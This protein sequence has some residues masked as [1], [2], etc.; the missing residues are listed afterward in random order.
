MEKEKTAIAHE[1]AVQALKAIGMGVWRYYPQQEKL[2]WDEVCRGIYHWPQAA[3]TFSQ[4]MDAIH[5]D[6]LLSA[7]SVLYQKANLHPNE[8]AVMEYRFKS[9]AHKGYIWI[10]VTG[11]CFFNAEGQP[12][13]LT[14]TAVDV[15]AEKETAAAEG[16]RKEAE[17]LSV[18]ERFRQAFENAAVGVVII[19]PQANIQMVNGA[20]CKMLGYTPEEL[21]QVNVQDISHP[22][23][24]DANGEF[25]QLAL[26]GEIPSFVLDK[27]YI[28]KQGKA[29]WGRLSASLVRH[30]DGSPDVFISIIEDITDKVAAR[31]EELKR[32]NME[33]QKANL[34]LRQSNHELEQYAYVASHDLQEPLRK[35]HVFTEMLRELP[36]LPDKADVL[37]SRITRSSER[38]SLLIRD[39]LEYS[40]L[41]Q[42]ENEFVAVDLNQV[43]DNVVS[44]FELSIAEKGAHVQVENLPVL[45]AIPLQMNQLFYNLF[46]NALKFTRPG[47]A[48]SVTI[49]CR[50][51]Q[52]Q[53]LT[54][55]ELPSDAELW[56]E[57]RFTDNGIGFDP[58][59]SSQIFEIFR[60]LHG[61]GEFQGAGIGLSLCRKIVQT[62]KGIIYPE[63]EEGKGT[64]FYI[65]LPVGQ[66]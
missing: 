52:R 12:E 19:D 51:V 63:S 22:E 21:Y 23:E 61:V 11:R 50:Q 13:L 31:T 54:A 64:A 39:L 57:I 66:G 8:P 3:I 24:M 27:R 7:Q 53:Q 20:F 16:K 1:M 33:L 48:P 18:G 65:I 28:T 36:G 44:D 32:S 9:P 30:D 34:S 55:R 14:G 49:S 42:S 26:K 56:Y 62:H 41:L 17:L 35:I 59:Y 15:T 60:R 46:S 37:L 43:V 10:R 58:K 4:L 47:T 2:E 38:M 29:V 25:I 40:R 45:R 6:D 5:P